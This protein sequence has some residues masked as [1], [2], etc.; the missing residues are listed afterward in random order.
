MVTL[1]YELFQKWKDEKK[2]VQVLRMD[3]AG[4]NIKLVK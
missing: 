2:E 1:T 3:K 4:E